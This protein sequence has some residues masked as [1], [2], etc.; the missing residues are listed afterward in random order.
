MTKKTTRDKELK[1]TRVAEMIKLNERFL[2]DFTPREQV[3]MLRLLL[4]ANDYGVVEVS[5]RALADMCEITRQNVR[6]VLTSLHEKGCVFLDVKQKTNPKSNPKGNPKSTFVTICN[7]DSYKVGRKKTTQN[8]TQKA[9]QNNDLNNIDN[10]RT[11]KSI[12]RNALTSQTKR[13]EY[14]HV[15]NDCAQDYRNF[16]MWLMNRAK[17]CFVNLAIPTPE[18]F[19]SLKLHSTGKDIAEMIEA[20][21]NNRKYDNM[22]KTIYLTARNWLK[23]DNKW[24]E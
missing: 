1:N 8:I 24:R 20:L 11:D 13:E 2:E 21:E 10:A 15:F 6:S 23:R 17:H 7:Y 19:T 22:Y 12:K 16:V 3:V 18:E 5:T 9:T 4:M 14:M